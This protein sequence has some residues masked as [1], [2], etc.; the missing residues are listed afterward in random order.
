[1]AAGTPWELVFD[2]ALDES[3]GI[4][5]GTVFSGGEIYARQGRS[6]V[7]MRSGPVVHEEVN[8]GSSAEAG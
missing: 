7:A 5:D 2:T 4:G 3:G 8:V 6:L 1:L